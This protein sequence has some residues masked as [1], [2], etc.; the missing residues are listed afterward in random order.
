[1]VKMAF[2]DSL[3][4]FHKQV[5]NVSQHVFVIVLWGILTSPLITITITHFFSFQPS[6][7]LPSISVT[8]TPVFRGGVSVTVTPASDVSVTRASWV[9]SVSITWT[10]VRGTHVL[11]TLSAPTEL[12]TS[13]APASLDTKVSLTIRE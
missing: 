11:T 9:H 12:A 4:T 10:R 2:C 3:Y 5:S 7:V 8:R 6:C 1:M 13:P